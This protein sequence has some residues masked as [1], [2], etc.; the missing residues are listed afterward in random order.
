MTEFS[1]RL[2]VEG[3]VQGVGY[4]YW[5]VSEATRWGIRGWVRNRSDQTVEILCIGAMD[6]IERFTE[7]CS[8]G[9]DGA[10]VTDIAVFPASDDGSIGFLALSTL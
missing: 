8:E 7:R 5:A 2:R 3:R 1:R 10:L 9:P 4:R 6:V